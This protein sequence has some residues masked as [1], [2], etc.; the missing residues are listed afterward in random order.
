[1]DTQLFFAP[2]SPWGPTLIT[3][4]LSLNSSLQLIFHQLLGYISTFGKLCSFWF[5]DPTVRQL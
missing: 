1:M 4:Q 5:M 2:S 3:I